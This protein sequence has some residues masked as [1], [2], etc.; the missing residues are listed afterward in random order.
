MCQKTIFFILFFSVAL[1]G[2]E[3]PDYMNYNLPVELRIRDL[4]SRMTIEEKISQMV[5]NSPAIER[6]GI[7]K[8]NWW[9]EALHGIARN[10]L[11]TVFPVPI[12][13]AAS[14]DRNLIYR[15]ADVIS[16]EARA[17]YNQ[18]VK[19]NKIGIFTGLTLWA[20]NI[21]IFRDPR[22]GRGMETYG[23]DPYLTGELAVQFI[24]GLQ[25][26][27]KRY[28]KTIAT[29]KH[30]AVHSG[31]EAERH[32]FNAIVNQYD[33]RET[34]LPHFEKSIKEGNAQSIMCA[35]NRLLGE[36]CCGS[37]MLLKKILRNEW[38]FNGLVVSDCWAI[39][40][41]FN[42]HKLT[43]SLEEA[44]SLSLIASTN[45]DCGNSYPLLLSALQKGLIKEQDVDNSLEKIF[46][47]RFK[48]GM[49][50]PPEL[51]PYSN[52]DENFL[53]T[54]E[55][56]LLALEAARKS[57][58]LLKNEKNILPLK[59]KYKRI[60]VVGPNANNLESL[61]GNYFGVPSEPIT[62]YKALQQKLI[63]SEVFYERGCYFAE[64]IPSFDIIE[65][66][67]LYTSF[68]KNQNGLIGEYFTNSHLIGSPEFSRVDNLIDF[69]WLDKSPV[70]NSDS[71]SVRWTGYLTPPES[72]LYAIGGFGFNG[73]RI[74]INDSLFL[75]YD[76]EF[77]PIITYN[78]LSLEKNKLYKIR[79]ELYKKSRYSFI[80][81]L[82]ALPEDISER[83]A[84]DAARNSDLVIM[85]MGLSPRL[86]GEALPV[87]SK[88]FYGGDRLT[89]DL[90][91]VQSKFIKKI[92][93]LG[94]PII[95]VLMNGSPLSVNWEN[96]NIPAI[97]EAWYPGQAGGTAIAE[98][99]LGE[100]NPSGRLPI[101][102]YKSVNQ[103]TDFRDYSMRNRTYR[104]FK[105]DVLYPFGYGLSY[106]KVQI[107]NAIIDKI[108][109][110]ENDTVRL[111]VDIKNKSNLFCEET[112]Q[113]YIKFPD[114]IEKKT[115]K[116]F[117]K[118]SLKP[119]EK[120]TVEFKIDYDKLK[121]WV[122]GKGYMVK[123]GKYT[124]LVGTSSDT[125]NA[126]K[127]IVRVK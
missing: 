67:F 66:K 18:A 36:P 105:G 4:I 47:I 40:D 22:W 91:E 11:A 44:I 82:W 8:Y 59:K 76:G 103:L 16:T 120:S 39:S 60:A 27:D 53:D 21:N 84:L 41:I 68:D 114:N 46:Y 25:G 32:H 50:D 48:L 86:E 100:Y 38:E 81:L 49:F 96:E 26:N 80:Q 28:F 34:Y 23:E 10:G 97:I 126:I 106:S 72:G 77:D 118:I 112:V 101:T 24:K 92:Y 71:F 88:E 70:T 89:L 83:K 64:K 13:L 56:K 57:I 98:I 123:K 85:F 55:N 31:P 104:Y 73:F 110:T 15:I 109:I 79:V 108:F 6:L 122:D 87:S 42:S 93:T 17:K 52:I 117:L 63:N 43:N 102:F 124:L 20:P 30:F 1:I 14:W 94:K 19:N 54:K 12:G 51:V 99:I 35:Y 3:K 29:P 65:S 107:D 37:N 2:Q 90:P 113:L 95:L 61:L 45:L 111:K 116:D 7:P 62:P 74:Y 115:L 121:K 78:F 5:H 69:C 58:V 33:L 125:S 127:K 119:Y 9:N 75:K